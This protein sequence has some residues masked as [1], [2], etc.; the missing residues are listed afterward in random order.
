MTVNCPDCGASDGTTTATCNTC[1]ERSAQEIHLAHRANGL[2][3]MARWC[4]VC[5][6]PRNID[7]RP[8]PSNVY[9]AE[10]FSDAELLRTAPTLRAP[11]AR[12]GRAR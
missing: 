10:P 8:R 7:T 3:D 4:P 9:R 2:D 1:Q 11:T 12:R 5:T 6:R